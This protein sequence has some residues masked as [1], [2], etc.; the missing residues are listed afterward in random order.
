MI[1]VIYKVFR[2]FFC[3]LLVCIEQAPSGT[4]VGQAVLMSHWQYED[5]THGGPGAPVDEGELEPAGR[6]LS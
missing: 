1:Q 5:G 6:C 3:I 4:R 2:T